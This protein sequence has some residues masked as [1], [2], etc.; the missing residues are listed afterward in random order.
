LASILGDHKEHSAQCAQK[1]KQVSSYQT[2]KKEI[3]RKTGLRRVRGAEAGKDEGDGVKKLKRKLRAGQNAK[4]GTVGK[5]GYD[6]L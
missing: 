4:E 6:Y 3:E 1:F 2:R 5:R